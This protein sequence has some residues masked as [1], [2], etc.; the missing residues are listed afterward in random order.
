MF[1]SCLRLF[2]W[3]WLGDLSGAVGNIMP[4][5]VGVEISESDAYLM[6]AAAT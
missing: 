5:S 4:L 2:E 3:F 1:G 6:T